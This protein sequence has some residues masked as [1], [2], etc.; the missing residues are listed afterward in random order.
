MSEFALSARIIGD[1]IITF[2]GSTILCIKRRSSFKFSNISSGG[3]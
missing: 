3:K 1:E 2:A